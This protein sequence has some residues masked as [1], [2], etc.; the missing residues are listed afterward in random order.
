[1]P[2]NTPITIKDG[3]ATPVDHVFNPVATREGNSQFENQSSSLTLEGREALK[4]GLKRA[5]PGGRTTVE[6]SVTLERPRMV[7][8]TGSGG[9]AAEVKLFTN[10]AILTLVVDPRSTAQERKDLRVMA[11]NALLN[12]QI[13]TAVDNAETFW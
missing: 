11:A 2:A 7:T 10:R 13:G 12:A 9:T 6:S 3:A 5:Q 1:M 4:I 8:G